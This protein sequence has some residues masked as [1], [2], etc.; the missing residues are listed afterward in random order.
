MKKQQRTHRYF[1][2]ELQLF[3]KADNWKSYFKNFISKYLKGQ[4]LEVGAGIGGSTKIL[5]DGK[6]HEW[7]C[8]EPDEK[9]S[10][11]I[12]QLIARHQLPG[13]CISETGYLKDV[14]KEKKFDAILYIDVIEHIK[15]DYEEIRNASERLNRN[16]VIIILVPAHNF[17]YSPYDKAIGHYRRYSRKMANSLIPQGFEVKRTVS[18]DIAG[19]FVLLVN[20]FFLRQK[21]PTLQQILFWDK[22]L[23][24]ISKILDRLFF[25]HIGKSLLLVIEKSDR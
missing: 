15:N 3:D 24:P 1:G 11:V 19:L 18:L 20:K 7:L 12:D 14:D 2:N 8:L 22:F 4:V 9:L 13:C 16:G 23:V 21:E 6:Q 10:L 25:F 17:L 5:C